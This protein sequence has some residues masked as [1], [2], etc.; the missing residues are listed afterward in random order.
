MKKSLN[1]SD[2]ERKRIDMKT[3]DQSLQ[4]LWYVVRSK[5]I[6]GSKCGRILCQRNKT[7]SLLRHCVYPKPLI[8]TPTPV[9][10]G[11]EHEAVAVKKYISYK[12][13]T[14]SVERCGFI[15]HPEK[16][17]LGASPD[18]KVKDLTSQQSNGVIEVKCPYTK[19]DCTPEEACSDDKF[20]CQIVNSIVRLKHD[21]NYY[22]QVQLQLYVCT[23]YDWCQW[24]DFCIFTR[25]GI[26][27]EH[28]FPDKDWEQKYIPEL[29][30]YFDENI[31]PELVSSKYKPAYVL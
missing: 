13:F 26:S 10:W 4:Q 19:R 27:V 23:E 25:K 3:R 24:C 14:V 11:I 16:G 2:Q 9:T 6:T 18:G 20:C 15:I 28:I 8:L 31:A 17:W 5:R 22:H 30:N 7:V 29:E 21:H 12:N 1:V